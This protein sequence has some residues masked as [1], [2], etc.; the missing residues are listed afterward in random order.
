MIGAGRKGAVLGET[1]VR[2]LFAAEIARWGVRGRRVLAIVPDHTRT[3]PIDVMF[4]VL[5]GL[6]AGEVEA[7]DVLIALGTHPPMTDDA[8]D[9]R[10][11]ISRSDRTGKYAKTKFFNHQWKDPGKLVSIGAITAEEVE[12]ISGGLMRERVDVT[13]N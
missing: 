6:L 9:Q 11:G 4:R 13:I 8:I 12:R 2:D 7:F 10:L 1:A 5:H 3:A